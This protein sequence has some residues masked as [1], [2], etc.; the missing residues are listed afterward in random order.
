MICSS[1]EVLCGLALSDNVFIENKPALVEE[2]LERVKLYAAYEADLLLLTHTQTKD[3]LTSL[4]DRISENINQYTYQI[5]N[6][7]DSL[8]LPKYPQDPIIRCFLNYCLPTL[9]QKFSQ[10]VLQ[11]IPDHHKK[12]I[13]SC[14][15]ASYMVYK[16]GFNG[17]LQ[18]LISCPLFW[19]GLN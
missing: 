17:P 2:I 15:I 13:I 11:E 6:Y 3:F 9:R 10:E 16:R 12:A 19:Q 5:L 1:F 18:L 4:S 7:F 14:H 8:S